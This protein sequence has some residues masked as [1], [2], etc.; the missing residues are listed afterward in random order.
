MT[1]YTPTPIN[2]GD[3][4]D[5]LTVRDNFDALSEAINCNVDETNLLQ[6]PDSRNLE[7][8][9]FHPGSVSDVFT[10][11]SSD[12]ASFLYF[13]RGA[14]F[15]GKASNIYDVDDCALRFYLHS[16]ADLF[17]FAN[18]Q[19]TEAIHNWKTLHGLTYGEGEI[20]V[21]IWLAFYLDG[22]IQWKNAFAPPEDQTSQRGRS[23]FVVSTDA[24]SH[25]GDPGPD[26]RG[27]S[28]FLH[29]SRLSVPRG[30]HSLKV[31]L[32]FDA[33]SPLPYDPSPYISSNASTSQYCSNF[34][35]ITAIANYT[36]GSAPVYT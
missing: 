13:A 12:A 31:K 14:E 34:R 19:L 16:P 8:S 29:G 33:T 7:K 2:D 20:T 15:Y 17:F 10:H 36:P 26:L 30:A 9:S 11:S 6:F 18:V 1:I 28:F 4:F 24:G 21:R 22:A 3:P 35:S 25:A 27:G 32:I 5:P 23:E